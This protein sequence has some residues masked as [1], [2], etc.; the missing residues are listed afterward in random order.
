M[1]VIQKDSIKNFADMFFVTSQQAEYLGKKALDMQAA[2]ASHAMTKMVKKEQRKYLK[3][4][5]E[6]TVAKNTIQDLER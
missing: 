2:L 6:L 5:G 4:N 3:V 1:P